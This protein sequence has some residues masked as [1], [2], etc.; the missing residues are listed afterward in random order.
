MVVNHN[1][2]PAAP[3]AVSFGYAN[4]QVSPSTTFNQVAP[5]VPITNQPTNH[6]YPITFPIPAISGPG[7]LQ[8]VYNVNGADSPYPEYYQCI[9][10]WV[11]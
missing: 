10:L 5:S 1:N 6:F 8:V 11:S 2:P 9:D 4:G 7:T 3:G